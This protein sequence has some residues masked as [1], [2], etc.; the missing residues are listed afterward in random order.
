MNPPDHITDRPTLGIALM[1]TGVASFAVMDATIKWLTT[2][3][4]V[5]QIVALRSWFGLP[6]LFFLVHLEGGT[7]QLKTGRPFAHFL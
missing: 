5:P 2:D 4:S 1:I 7:S 3:F 6:L